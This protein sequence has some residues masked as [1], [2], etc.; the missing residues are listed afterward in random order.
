MCKCA[1]ATVSQDLVRHESVFFLS[2]LY[3]LCTIGQNTRA[4]EK[5]STLTH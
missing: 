2:L 4:P 5:F 1:D 3:F